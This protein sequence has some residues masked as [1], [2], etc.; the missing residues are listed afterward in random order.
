MTDE[1]KECPFCGNTNIRLT[2]F[3]GLPAVVCDR[4]GAS[5]V[6]EQEYKAVAGWNARPME[7][8]LRAEVERLTAE[9]A[10]AKERHEQAARALIALREWLWSG[11]LS[12]TQKP[13]QPIVAPQGV[14]DIVN[15]A[16]DTIAD[17]EA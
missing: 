15:A 14:A 11:Q 9:L 6:S 7:Y 1:L 12:N 13:G 4:C 17:G 3:R 8:A 16:L 10:A 2:T 5:T